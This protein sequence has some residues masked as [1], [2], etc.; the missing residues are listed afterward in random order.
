M[1]LAFAAGVGGGGLSGLMASTSYYF[2]KRLAGTALGLQA[3]I[4]NLG[5]GLMQ[6][7]LP[8]VVGFGLFGTAIL[9][10]QSDSEGK[11]VWLH[12]GGLVLI[13]W[14]L[15]AVALAIL[16][17]R[18]VPVKAN[19]RQQLDIFRLKHTWIMM[20][21]YLVSFGAFSGL[22]AQSSPSSAGLGRQPE[23][24]PRCS[25]SVRPRSMSLP[26]SSPE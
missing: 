8:W 22:A 18:S 7:L 23:P 19:F 14:V 17:I 3:G 16:V 21:I 26:V 15:L 11:L 9:T 5:I 10:P 12:N 25:S 20:A 13:P 6:L 4:G 2:P 1:S 24:L